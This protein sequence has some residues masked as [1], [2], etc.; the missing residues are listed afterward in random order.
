MRV[1][2]DVFSG[3]PNPTWRLKP[4]QARQVAEQLN[5]MTRQAAAPAI[6]QAPHAGL[7]FRGFVIEREL[8]DPPLPP[9]TPRRLNIT[10]RTVSGRRGSTEPKLNQMLLE[11]A[12]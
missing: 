1:M 9:G 7:G 8:D 5:P 4:A 3:R 2:M 10:P 11:W 6:A 12:A